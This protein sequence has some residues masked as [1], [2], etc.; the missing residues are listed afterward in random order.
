[1]KKYTYSLRGSCKSQIRLTQI[2]TF[3]N[4]NLKTNLQT[5]LQICQNE[6]KGKFNQEGGIYAII[7]LVSNELYIGQ[8][9]NIPQRINQHCTKTHNINLYNAIKKHGL[10]NFIIAAFFFDSYYSLPNLDFKNKNLDLIKNKNLDLIKNKNDPGIIKFRKKLEQLE[11]KCIKG[12]DLKFLYNKNKTD[13][14]NKTKLN[15]EQYNNDLTIDLIIKP[16]LKI[17]FNNKLDSIH[18]V[19]Y[20]Y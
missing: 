8:S 3:T 2:F 9:I 15:L 12:F 18:N 5:N 7:N 19:C 10:H 13:K 14:K 16:F 1:M 6:L 17:L 20:S 11:T 4:L